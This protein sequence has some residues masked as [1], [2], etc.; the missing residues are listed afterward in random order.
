MPRL[1][2][3]FANFDLRRNPAMKA[4]LDR[5]RA[6]ASG[7]AWGA[8]LWGGLGCGKTHLAIAALNAWIERH[9]TGWFWKAPDFLGWVREQAFGGEG[10][11]VD[12]LLRPYREGAFL[13]VLDDLGTE[14][15]TDWAAEQLYRVLD[16]R[17]DF[18]LPTIITTNQD[19]D[20]LDGRL[21]S[22]FRQGL[23]V[24]DGVDVRAGA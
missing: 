13:L 12:D 17:Y 2:D 23:V 1:S 7:K 5:C 6:V 20:R 16:S 22:R 14:N 3:T 15:P 19:L 11:A 24:C 10:W 8:M 4:A 21:V 9:G 18:R